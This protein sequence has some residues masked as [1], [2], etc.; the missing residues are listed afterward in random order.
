MLDLT[1]EEPWSAVQEVITCDRCLA[2]SSMQEIFSN[3]LKWM[4]DSSIC[5]AY[6][7]RLL[8]FT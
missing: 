2:Y 4:F 5:Y 7:S 6:R 8:S 1:G 3:S